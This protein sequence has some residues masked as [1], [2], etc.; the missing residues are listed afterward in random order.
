[1]EL[2][3]SQ[4]PW[5]S[6][7]RVKVGTETLTDILKHSRRMRSFSELRKSHTSTFNNLPHNCTTFDAKIA[8]SDGYS[9]LPI[10]CSHFLANHELPFTSTQKYEISSHT[11]HILKLNTPIR[12]FLGLLSDLCH[13]AGTF[14][15]A[16]YARGRQCQNPLE[17]NH[18]GTYNSE[19][20]TLH[21]IAKPV[22]SSVRK[23]HH[24]QLRP[25]KPPHRLLLS[26]L[27]GLLRPWWLLGRSLGII[28]SSDRS[29][30]P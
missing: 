24:L 25:Q 30:T 3:D 9:S 13:D 5:Y 6:A 10:K 20:P 23:R 19:Q 11:A 22:E 18:N 14:G 1:M 2:R 8:D 4:L 15:F 16:L 12:I 28:I 7:R 26:M 17:A 21:H 29:C 27:R